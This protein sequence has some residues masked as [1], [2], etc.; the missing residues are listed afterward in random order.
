MATV[1]LRSSVL[2]SYVKTLGMTSRA[3]LCLLFL[4]WGGR[5]SIASV[6]FFSFIFFFFYYSFATLDL[7]A[8]EGAP[9]VNPI[10][11]PYSLPVPSSH[12]LRERNP[13]AL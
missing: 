2:G 6:V 1:V 4:N 10:R 7:S 13:L 3:R 9:F 11:S 8:P 12:P 5:C